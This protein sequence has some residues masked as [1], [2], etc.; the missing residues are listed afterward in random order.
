VNFTSI[1]CCIQHNID[2]SSSGANS[3]LHQP[4][5]SLRC[6]GRAIRHRRRYSE[7]SE[8]LHSGG[9]V[10]TEQPVGE[11][12]PIEHGRMDQ[13]TVLQW[14]KD[15]CAWMGLVKFDLL[16]LGMLAALQYTIDLVGDHV[17]ETWALHT[18]PRE[19][20]RCM[21]GCAGRTRS[22]CSRSSPAPRWPPCPG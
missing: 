19:E 13:R 2:A 17:G 9:M 18:I 21:T 20:P 22:G 11:V 15:D 16:G 10:L 12:V 1:D 3:E 8:G 7:G 5:T 14:D 6:L 4:F